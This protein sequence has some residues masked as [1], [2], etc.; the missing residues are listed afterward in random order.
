[1]DIAAV[2]D[3]VVFLIIH[4]TVFELPVVL[5]ATAVA[6]YVLARTLDRHGAR[7]REARLARRIA[8]FYAAFFAILYTARYFFL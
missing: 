6:A 2:W 7:T 1:M 5:V 8:L 4:V 3:K